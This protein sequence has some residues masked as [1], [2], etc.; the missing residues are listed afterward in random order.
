MP[1]LYARACL[2]PLLLASRSATHSRPRLRP[3]AAADAGGAAR[4]ASRRGSG[5]SPPSP[6]STGSAGDHERQLVAVRNM[7]YETVGASTT[8]AVARLLTAFWA[9]VTL[10]RLL[11]AAT[12]RWLPARIGFR[13][14]APSSSSVTFALTA[15]P[16]RTTPRG[17][18]SVAVFAPGRTR[19]APRSCRS[20]S[21]SARP[22]WPPCRR[23]SPA[24]SSRS[25]R[26]ATESPPSPW[27]PPRR[28]RQPSLAV[29]V[30]GWTAIAA[31]AALA[32]LS[33]AVAARPS[34]LRAVVH[35]HGLRAT[36][37]QSDSGAAEAA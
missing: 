9:M 21:A 1:V 33:F 24:G 12:A 34:P 25:T 31:A 27:R 15:S 8:Q 3:A 10:A 19:A 11:F 28:P 35:G 23:P 36:N 4:R 26:S 32:L 17:F 7:T 22:R 29:A 2:V 37:S 5:S 14:A 16:A 18:E 30:T 20:R 6:C 13:P